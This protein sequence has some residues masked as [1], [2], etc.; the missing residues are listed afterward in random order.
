MSFS[1]EFIRTQGQPIDVDGHPVVGIL[2]HQV[3]E[4]DRVRISWRRWIAT[5][6]QGI[7]LGLHG[8]SIS[9]DGRK[10]FDIVLWRDTSPDETVLVCNQSGELRMWNCWRIHHDVIQAWVGNAGMRVH[11]VSDDRVIA[12]CNSRTEVTFQD[13]VFEIVVEHAKP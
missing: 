9:V 8:G 13:L 4:G 11:K 3:Q 12:E 5:P 1:E 6:V 7:S 10:H 2:R